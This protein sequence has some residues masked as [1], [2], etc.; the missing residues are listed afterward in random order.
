M[1]LL[2]WL[3]S[4]RRETSIIQKYLPSTNLPAYDLFGGAGSVSFL[5]SKL[6]YNVTWNDMDKRLYKMMRVVQ[7][8][9]YV[10]LMNQ[11]KNAP[12]TV[13]AFRF[14]KKRMNTSTLAFMFAIRTSLYGLGTT[15]RIKNGRLSGSPYADL[16]IFHK[17]LQNIKLTNRDAMAE[18]ERLKGRNVFIYLD[19]PYCTGVGGTTRYKHHGS[20]EYYERIAEIMKS[21]QTKAKIMLHTDYTDVVRKLFPPR[22]IREKYSFVYN[23]KHKGKTHSIMSNFKN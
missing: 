9:G 4:K 16:T 5:L 18:L 22:F 10:K 23:V 13:G 3:G 12:R 11:L 15:P 14:F 17:L 20:V 1:T 8:S 2:P 6:G 7:G 19:P 21:N